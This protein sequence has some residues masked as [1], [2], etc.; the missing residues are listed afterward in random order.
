M[1]K[2]YHICNGL[3]G[4]IICNTVHVTMYATNS[5]QFSVR[6]ALT[7]HACNIY[8]NAKLF[9]YVYVQKTVTPRGASTGNGRG[10]GFER[11][12]GLGT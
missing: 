11:A 6:A 12:E 9:A 2:D 8:R 4:A 1:G 7:V 10:S 5:L 3:C